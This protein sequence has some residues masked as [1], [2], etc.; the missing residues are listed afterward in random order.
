MK[1]LHWIA[2]AGEDQG[3]KNLAILVISVCGLVLV[4]Y[5]FM[6]V[7]ARMWSPLWAVSPGATSEDAQP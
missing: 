5:A 6:A 3:E 2:K 1:R 4:L 7:R